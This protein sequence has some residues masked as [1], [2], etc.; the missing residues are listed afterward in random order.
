[1]MLYVNGQEITKLVLG[2]LE[3][4]GSWR[5]VPTEYPT[6]PEEY[7]KTIELFLA[8]TKTTLPT[9]TGFVLVQGP[10]SATALRTSHALINALAFALHVPVISVLKPVGV[11]DAEAWQAQALDKQSKT[12]VALPVYT[13]D[14]KITASTRDALKRKLS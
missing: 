9:M 12:A 8:A 11:L 10:G 5:Q 4:D 1:M 2:L 3:V 13:S 7:L 6:S 14:P